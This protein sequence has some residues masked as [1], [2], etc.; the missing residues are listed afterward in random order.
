MS[1]ITT[2]LLPDTCDP[3]RHE[4]EHVLVVA[5]TDWLRFCPPRFHRNR[6]VVCINTLG[7]LKVKV[8]TR[9]ASGDIAAAFG[10]TLVRP[11]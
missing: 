6:R 7:Q 4:H 5:L 1:L 10:A 8:S 9:G 2:K 11:A 3:A